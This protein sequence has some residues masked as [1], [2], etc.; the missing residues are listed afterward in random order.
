MKRT[1]S[2]EFL[3]QVFALIIAVI[4]VHAI[5]VTVVRPQATAIIAEQ[6]LRIQEDENW[7]CCAKCRDDRR[8]SVRSQ[9]EK[10]GL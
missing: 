3:Y 5:Y 7:N 8:Q 10:S 6:T 9:G 1:F 2:S 4:I